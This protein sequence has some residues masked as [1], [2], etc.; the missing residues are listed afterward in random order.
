MENELES[1]LQ[2][3]ISDLDKKVPKDNAF[4]QL[5]EYGGGAD[6]SKIRAN[7]SGYLRLGIELL[8]AAFENSIEHDEKYADQVDVDID[9]LITEDSSINFDWFERTEKRK[10]IQFKETLFDRLIPFVA[11]TIF[12]AVVILAIIGFFSLF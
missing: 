4:V 11:L 10:G 7:Q 2:K 1:Y 3:I 12:L 8:K 5:T 6:E 9:Y